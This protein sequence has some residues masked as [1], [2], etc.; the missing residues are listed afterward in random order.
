MLD[1]ERASFCIYIIL[2]KRKERINIL[3]YIDTSR[4]QFKLAL[5]QKYLLK[6]KKQIR[7]LQTQAKARKAMHLYAKTP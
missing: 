4:V 7:R 5:I 6:E 2:T 1:R 3:I